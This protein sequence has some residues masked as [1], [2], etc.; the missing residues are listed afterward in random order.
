MKVEK[1]VEK[2][3]NLD[4]NQSV[5]FQSWG[6]HNLKTNPEALN[7][8]IENGKRFLEHGIQG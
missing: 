5:V 3:N 8:Y 7:V 4:L 1:I 6:I 2:E